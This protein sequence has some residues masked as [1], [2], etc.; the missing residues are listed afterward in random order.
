MVLMK[1]RK[2]HVI[3]FERLNYPAEASQ[4]LGMAFEFGSAGPPC[5]PPGPG[6]QGRARPKGLDFPSVLAPFIWRDALCE[7]PGHLGFLPR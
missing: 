4:P 7:H 2:G 6:R 1:D 5:R 3:G